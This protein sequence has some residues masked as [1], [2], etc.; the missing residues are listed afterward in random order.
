MTE[1]EPYV[2]ELAL[3]DLDLYLPREQRISRKW[4]IVAGLAGL[5]VLA[6]AAGGLALALGAG[7]WLF[8]A[9]AEAQPVAT[10]P[11]V[12]PAL[13]T[14][15]PLPVANLSIWSQTDPGAPVGMIEIA[16][17]LPAAARLSFEIPAGLRYW[18]GDLLQA[19]EGF[20]YNSAGPEE[21]SWFLF[22]E[23]SVIFP[24]SLTISL[25][26]RATNIPLRPD[27]STTLSIP[28]D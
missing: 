1:Q 26:G 3:E 28:L 9:P 11:V 27:T 18:S 2:D 22:R 5:L 21:V 7:A 13:P 16:L 23:P 8:S 25:D 17:S 20:A 12:R 14:A 15:T 24:L 4:L 10:H 6:L 19:G